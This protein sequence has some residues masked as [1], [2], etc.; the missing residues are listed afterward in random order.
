MN[1]YPTK[2]F[3]SFLRRTKPQAPTHG[4]DRDRIDAL[5]E[6][7][8]DATEPRIREVSDYLEKLREAAET[9]L[10]YTDQL[11]SRIPGTIEIKPQSLSSDR[12]VRAIFSTEEDLHKTFRRSWE[13]Y[14][15]ISD[16]EG[17]GDYWAL[18]CMHQERRPLTT[19]YK[20]IGASWLDSHRAGIHFS[21]QRINNP[22]PSETAARKSLHDC[23][24]QGLLLTAMD[25]ASTCR[26]LAER[27]DKAYHPV[28]S[29]LCEEITQGDHLEAA[30]TSH[31]TNSRELR[32]RMRD[33]SSRVNSA[34]QRLQK[35][36][37]ST[38]EAWIENLNEVLG[39]P[40]NYVRVRKVK[41]PLKRCTGV[42]KESTDWSA[43]TIELA[44]MQVANQSPRYVVL[45][46][47]SETLVPEISEQTLPL[48]GR[49]PCVVQRSPCQ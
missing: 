43:G 31:P 18:I 40:D 26:K 35:R 48:D 5:I 14:D 32:R 2:P 47:L 29:R 15:Y 42:V 24:L 39:H 30:P 16:H 49:D 11:V 34:A 41:I 36:G 10:A 1:W 6:R 28:H 8:I 33:I 19:A 38:P 17:S 22:G 7:A 13:L 3:A 27:L 4:I 20:A 25:H 12:R 46:R 37:C 9:M 44:E 45:A 23:I 21:D